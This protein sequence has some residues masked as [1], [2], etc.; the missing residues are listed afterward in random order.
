MSL[1]EFKNVTVDR[2]RFEVKIYAAFITLNVLEPLTNT[3]YVNS[4]FDYK[5]EL[6]FPKSENLK[7]LNEW[8][9]YQRT[10]DALF[11]NLAKQISERD[12]AI[13]PSITG[14]ANIKSQ[15]VKFES[16]INKCK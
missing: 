1:R 11:S 12:D 8:D 3:S 6:V 15:L 5:N 2:D 7:I 4:K 10:Q 14:T 9:V 13:L 16:I